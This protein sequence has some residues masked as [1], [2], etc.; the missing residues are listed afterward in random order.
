MKLK[1]LLELIGKFNKISLY[2]VSSH[3]GKGV[4]EPE[5]IEDSPIEILDQYSDYFIIDIS[6][7][8]D[9]ND[10]AYIDITI[11]KELIYD[12]NTLHTT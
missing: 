8:T 7:E 3:G 11:R 1:D 6:A 2:L 10:T 9:F 5:W 4:L 12:W